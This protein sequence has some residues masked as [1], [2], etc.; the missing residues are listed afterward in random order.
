MEDLKNFVSKE[1]VF[2]LYIRQCINTILIKNEYVKKVKEY[3]EYLEEKIAND[4]KYSYDD[5]Y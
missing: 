3:F 4:L 5:G 1:V 2:N